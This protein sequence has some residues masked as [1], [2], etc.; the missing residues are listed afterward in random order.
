[1]LLAPGLLLGAQ[2]FTCTAKPGDQDDATIITAHSTLGLQQRDWNC[3]SG[4]VCTMCF[5]LVKRICD[6]AEMQEVKAVAE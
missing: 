3:P 4:S 6:A 2:G 1:M 5:V